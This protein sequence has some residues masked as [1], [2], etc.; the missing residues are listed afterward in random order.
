MITPRQTR[1]LRVADLHAFRETLVELCVA[2]A[3]TP[4]SSATGNLA[5]P[6]VTGAEADLRASPL[7][8]VPTRGAAHQLARTLQR[9]HAGALADA[10]T[11]D[12]LYDRLHARLPQPPR[13][14]DG[15]RARRHR[16]GRRARSDGRRRR[17]LP[18]RL[19]PGLVAEILRFYDHLRRQSQQVQRFEELIDSSCRGR[20]TSDPRRRA[21]AA[22]DAVSGRRVSR[23]RAARV[24]RPARATS[25][26]CANA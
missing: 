6:T 4:P 24:A 20:W 8:V 13:A 25:T 18:F 19:R 2:G 5:S 26:R 12:Q 9:A 7:V 14:A 23:I 3:D 15:V 11:R 22:A 17:P 21:D 16:A 1:L 10:A